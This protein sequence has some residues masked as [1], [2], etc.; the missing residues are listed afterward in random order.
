MIRL[1]LDQ[2]LRDR[3]FTRYKLAKSTGIQYHIIDKYYKNTVT[4]YDSYVLDR[5]CD[6]LQCD[7]ADIIQYTQ[8][9]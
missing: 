9:Q 7:I 4:R 1:T 3:Q 6:V 5:I 2:A 8:N